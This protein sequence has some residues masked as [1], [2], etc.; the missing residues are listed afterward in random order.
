[1]RHWGLTHLLET[2]KRHSQSC[3]GDNGGLRSGKEPVLREGKMELDQRNQ[4][5]VGR[6]VPGASLPCA[7]GW[8]AGGGGGHQVRGGPSPRAADTAAAGA[9]DPLF[10][11]DR[12][13]HTSPMA[14]L[15]TDPPQPQDQHLS[16][17]NTLDGAPATGPPNHQAKDW[18]PIRSG[19]KLS[20]P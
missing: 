13:S 14:S 15:P 20:S 5:E 11:L 1:M 18:A 8:A 6:T 12:Q 16:P 2:G 9:S 4:R 19:S 3:S 17:S 7:L 10:S